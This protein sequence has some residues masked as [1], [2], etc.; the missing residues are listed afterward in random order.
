MTPAQW[1]L[2]WT[3]SPSQGFLAGTMQTYG[4]FT[5]VAC[6]PVPCASACSRCC[7]S[8]GSGWLHKGS[9]P[10]GPVPRSSALRSKQGR[11]PGHWRGE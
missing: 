2:C 11:A 10:R 1:S 9:R 4:R 5:G 8:S 7:T 6:I 3:Q